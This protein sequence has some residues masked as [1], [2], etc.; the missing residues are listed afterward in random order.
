MCSFYFNVVQF[1]KKII[2]IEFLIINSI[3]LWVCNIGI[4]DAQRYVF[5]HRYRVIYIDIVSQY[6]ISNDIDIDIRYND[7]NIIYKTNNIK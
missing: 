7:R 5:Y 4:S 1:I 6:R 3:Y 2:W